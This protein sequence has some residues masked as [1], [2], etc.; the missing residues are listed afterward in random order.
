[1]NPSAGSAAKGSPRGLTAV[2]IFLLFGAVMA[3]MAPSRI[4]FCHLHDE[5]AE[6]LRNSWPTSLRLPFPKQ[7][8][9]PAMPA[10]Q[11]SGLT[12]TKASFQLQR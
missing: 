3:F 12:I 2:G 6:V 1:M 5:F 11:V 9:S 7:P 4:L 10:N 8:E